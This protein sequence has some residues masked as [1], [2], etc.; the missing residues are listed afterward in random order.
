MTL[1]PTLHLGCSVP[2]VCCASHYTM[3]SSVGNGSRRSVVYER[4]VGTYRKTWNVYSLGLLGNYR[5]DG[6]GR[7]HN[8]AETYEQMI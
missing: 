6:L 8:E 5:K 1:K 7:G 3:V 4:G 2:V